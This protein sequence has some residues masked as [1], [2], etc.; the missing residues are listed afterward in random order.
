MIRQLLDRALL[1]LFA[2][3]TILLYAPLALLALPWALFDSLGS[4]GHTTFRGWVEGWAI[5]SKDS[6]IDLWRQLTKP[7][8]S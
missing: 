8:R 5:Y 4:W 6:F 7:V 3:L 2:V 1:L